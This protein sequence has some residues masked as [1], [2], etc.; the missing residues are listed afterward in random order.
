M[1]RPVGSSHCRL[2]SGT[3]DITYAAEAKGPS[4]ACELGTPFGAW[5][6]RLL[7]F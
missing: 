6:S 5:N 1:E 2:D 7:A 3:P 4:G